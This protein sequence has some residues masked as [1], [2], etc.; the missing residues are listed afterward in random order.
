M[1]TNPRF[2][3]VCLNNTFSLLYYA[4][5]FNSQNPD[6]CSATDCIYLYGPIKNLNISILLL[7]QTQN[8][9]ALKTIVK[10]SPSSWYFQV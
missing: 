6:F 8:Y 2:L 4:I 9:A 7:P 10:G 3:F 5:S 1:N